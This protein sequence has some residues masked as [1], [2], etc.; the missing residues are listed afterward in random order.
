MSKANIGSIDVISERINIFVICTFESL[1]FDIK[2]LELYLQM[3]LLM[4]DTF[5]NTVHIILNIE[6]QIEK[7]VLH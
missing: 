3:F 6:P 7:I 5:A 4:F 2:T 1:V